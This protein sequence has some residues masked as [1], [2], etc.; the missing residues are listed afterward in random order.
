MTD[1]FDP[2]SD[3]LTQLRVKK[4]VV[5]APQ[6]G[7][8]HLQHTPDHMYFGFMMW[9]N[10]EERRKLGTCMGVGPLILGYM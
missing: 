5:P 7:A 3:N 4:T 6:E 9:S 10:E 8:Q 2:L 1:V